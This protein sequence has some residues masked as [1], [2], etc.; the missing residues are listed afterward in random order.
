[1]PDAAATSPAAVS[2]IANLMPANRDPQTRCA[3]LHG[4]F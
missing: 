4:Y 1:M 2:K 3:P